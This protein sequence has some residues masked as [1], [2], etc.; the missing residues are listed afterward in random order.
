MEMQNKNY[1]LAD[2]RIHGLESER[3]KAKVQIVKMTSQVDAQQR[4]IERAFKVKE[5]MATSFRAKLHHI[6]ELVE[7]LIGE[8]KD[9]MIHLAQTKMNLQFIK[10]LQ[11]EE[12]P[13]I[14]K[15]AA[16]L[17]KTVE[18]LAGANILSFY[19]CLVLQ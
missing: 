17:T 11:A 9:N 15:E 7:K 14:E 18:E 10:L 19:T 2:D 4:H 6:Q 8:L 1:E 13:I 16:E 12:P 5:E 3:A